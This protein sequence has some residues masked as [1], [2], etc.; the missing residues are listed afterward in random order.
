MKDYYEILEV[1]HDASPEVIEKAYKTL[2]FKH[3][4]DRQPPDQRNRATK[5][6]QDLNEAYRVLSDP[7][8]RRVHGEQRSG[9]ERALRMLLIFW[10]DG[11]LGLA[12]F[13]LKG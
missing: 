13:W 2:S 7:I 1:H 4:P 6:M 11:L 10:E 12:K 5:K 3:H 9:T 8:L